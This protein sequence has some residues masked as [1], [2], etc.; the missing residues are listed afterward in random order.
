MA[1]ARDARISVK[2]DV[3]VVSRDF[4]ATRELVFRAWRTAEHMRH[5]FSPD[6]CS[7]T[8][9][10]VDFRPGGACVLCM[11]LPDGAEN[12]CRGHYVEI[13]PPDRLVIDFDVEV[14]GVARFSA[15]TSVTFEGV[16][17]VTRMTVRQDYE[18]FDEA[19][20]GAVAGAREGWRTTLDKLEAELARMQAQGPSAAVHGSFSVARS[21]RAAPARVFR[22]LTDQTEKSHWF[23][24]GNGQEIL[25]REMDVRPGGR[26]RVRGRW[27]N[28]TVSTFD[29]TYFDVVADRRLIYAYEMHLDGRK[30]S[31][32]LAT[33]DL[34]AEGAG[35]RLTVTEQGVFLDGYQDAG[36]RERGTGFLLDRL[37][38]ALD[39]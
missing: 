33:L 39:G 19:Y 3:L 38:A 2:S 31:V 10:E 6:V 1:Q 25:E 5:W 22:A 30:I 15:L 32:S 29:A 16:G 35:T 37:R 18:I 20:V 24:G 36:S 7:V 9:A 34:A 4:R 23:G 14:D 26:E 8:H 17:P 28:G 27:A 11:R 21:Y 13:V 12:W